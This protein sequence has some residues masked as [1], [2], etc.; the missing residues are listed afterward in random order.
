[1]V[2]IGTQ[3]RQ[4]MEK[5]EEASGWDRKR[6]LPKHRGIGVGVSDGHWFLTSWA[7]R[8][9]AMLKVQ[10]DGTVALQTGATDVGQV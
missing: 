6:K 8:L 9:S 10:E 4:A 1:M 2:K 3:L 7:F 5:G